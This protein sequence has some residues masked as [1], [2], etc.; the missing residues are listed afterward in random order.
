[1]SLRDPKG[2]S[3]LQGDDET[4]APA[5]TLAPGAHLPDLL[6]KSGSARECRGVQVLLRR[7]EALIAITRNLKYGKL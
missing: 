2:R 6:S 3:N 1:M 4:L 5:R 7:V